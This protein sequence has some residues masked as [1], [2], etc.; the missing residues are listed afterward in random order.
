M[1][2][3]NVTMSDEAAPAPN[4]A[5][6]SLDNSAALLILDELVADGTVTKA[7]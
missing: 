5:I 2:L 1:V 3:G 7:V 4:V 6:E